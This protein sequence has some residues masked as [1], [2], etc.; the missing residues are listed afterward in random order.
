MGR[1]AIIVAKQ[2]NST[3][4][5]F[6]RFSEVLVPSSEN[7]LRLP[8]RLRL[9][10]PRTFPPLTNQVYRDGFLVLPGRQVDLEKRPD[11]RDPNRTNPTSPLSK[12]V[13]NRTTNCPS[14]PDGNHISLCYPNFT[15]DGILQELRNKSMIFHRFP[16]GK[17]TLCKEAKGE[18]I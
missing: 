18:G 7:F 4:L 16:F 14:V 13:L 5:L 9:A 3:C 6:S 1:A 15:S 10:I 8:L 11:V 17:K 12:L 2:N